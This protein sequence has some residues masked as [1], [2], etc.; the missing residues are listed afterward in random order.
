M[1]VPTGANKWSEQ[2]S[3]RGNIKVKHPG[4]EVAKKQKQT[5]SFGLTTPPNWLEEED[6]GL[7][8]RRHSH[9]K[10]AMGK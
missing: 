8:C 9:T 7:G 5:G 3:K 2:K 4:T 1:T 10:D 6:L